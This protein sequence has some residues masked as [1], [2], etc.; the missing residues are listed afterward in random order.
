VRAVTA[1]SARTNA[2]VVAIALAAIA[3]WAALSPPGAN[4]VQG[5]DEGYY[6]TMARNILADARGL[7]S[8]A[9]T[10]L[11]PPGDKP[12]VYPAL[13]AASVRLLGPTAA[14]LR[15]PSLLLSG[16]IVLAAARLTRR[17][18]GGA[19][20]IA[21]ALF[22]ATLPA[23]SYSARVAAA[24]IPLAAFGMLALALLAGGRPSPRRALAAGALLGLAFL[25]KLWLV[26]LVAIPAIALIVPG[27]PGAPRGTAWRTL[28]TVASGAV[29]VGGLQL[30]AVAALEPRHIA[31][32]IDVYFRFS[33]ASRVAGAGF[34]PDWIKPPDYY[35][36]V[37]GRSFLLLLP[38]IA[39]GAWAATRRLSEPAPRAILVGA[40]GFVP[41]SFFG[42]K[43]GFYLVPVMPA[44]AALAALGFTWLIAP[45]ATGTTGRKALALRWGAMALGAFAALAGLVRQTQRLPVRYHDPGFRPVAAALAPLL[46]DVPAERASFVA[47]EAPAFAYYLFKSGRYWG[48]PLAPWSADQ[49]AVIA[50]DSSLR[51]FV[52][53]PA[54]RFYGGW[55]DSSTLAWL[56]RDTRE[57]TAEIE[58]A[59]GR[60]LEVRA[61]VRR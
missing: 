49:L 11:G 36:L 12:P 55:P 50:A 51:A 34:A 9:Q 22:L 57:I 38:F 33:L 37:L 14:A 15:W 25:C 48:T 42:V 16:V 27:P 7:V 40:L 6:G 41:L 28:L 2:G 1:S 52:V 59:A 20:A 44:W 60:R 8:P 39:A 23:F 26:A 24:E 21:A 30:A 61:F 18:A 56:E 13:L 54:E 10:P 3:L 53:D 29:A 19:G 32:W 5:G 4:D 46:R 58:R 17:A 35:A 45:R 43:S 31:H 47:P